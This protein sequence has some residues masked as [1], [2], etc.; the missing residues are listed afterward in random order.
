MRPDE[1]ELRERI[2]D[3]LAP[4]PHPAD[5]ADL[6][7]MVQAIRA[8]GP[9]GTPS[10]DAL[11]LDALDALQVTAGGRE[12][13]PSLASIRSEVVGRQLFDDVVVRLAQ[14]IPDAA[15]R[16]S[17]WTGQAPPAVW[18]QLV[19]RQPADIVAELSHVLP[20]ATSAAMKSRLSARSGGIWGIVVS[21][22]SGHLIAIEAA[23]EPG[24]PVTLRGA[25]P[26]DTVFRDALA[27]AVEAVGAWLRAQGLPGIDAGLGVVFSCSQTPTGAALQDDSIALAAALALVE[28]LTGAT[29]KPGGLCATGALTADGRVHPVGGA[30][31]KQEAFSRQM[32]VGRI[33]T[34]A[35]AEFPPE[36]ATATIQDAVAEAF[37]DTPT[38]AAR[39]RATR[40]LDHVRCEREGLLDH[41]HGPGLVAMSGGPAPPS[42]RGALTLPADLLARAPDPSLGEQTLA[43]LIAPAWPGLNPE[44]GFAAAAGKLGRWLDGPGHTPTVVLTTSN[45]A[46][47]AWADTLRPSAASMQV[48]LWR[49][50]TLPAAAPDPAVRRLVRR[51]GHHLDLRL[52]PTGP[53]AAGLGL[54][55]PNHPGRWLLLACLL[56]VGG[57]ATQATRST[58]PT[59]A[60]E[61][62]NAVVAD[63]ASSQTDPPTADWCQDALTELEALLRIPA[64]S[65]ADTAAFRWLADTCSQ[66]DEGLS[67]QARIE[68]LARATLPETARQ[69]RIEL[70]RSLAE[71]MV[72]DGYRAILDDL[73]DTPELATQTVLEQASRRQFGPLAHTRAA[74][75]AALAPLARALQGQQSTGLFPV[76]VAV[77]DGGIVL[78]FEDHWEL[79]GP[80]ASL[81]RI[82]TGRWPNDGRVHDLRF[83][84]Q[85]ARV[86]ASWPHNRGDGRTHLLLDPTTGEAEWIARLPGSI[87]GIAHWDSRL[88]GRRTTWLAGG[89]SIRAVVDPDGTSLPNTRQNALVYSLAEVDRGASQPPGLLIGTGEFTG[90]DLALWTPD[91]EGPRRLG[92]VRANG[93]PSLIAPTREPDTFLVAIGIKQPNTEWL[94]APSHRGIARI[95]RLRVL[96]DGRLQLDDRPGLAVP[97]ALLPSEAKA[98]VFSLLHLGPI[99]LEDDT[100]ELV[101]TLSVPDGAWTLL[102]RR[103]DAG[104]WTPLWMP[105]TRVVG[106][107]DLDGDDKAEVL[108]HRDEGAE[109][110]ILGLGRQPPPER[111][112]AL[113][114]GRPPHPDDAVAWKTARL[115]ER[116]AT[117]LAAASTWN[118]LASRARRTETATAARRHQLRTL[119]EAGAL[120]ELADAI[121]RMPDPAAASPTERHAFAALHRFSDALPLAPDD[122]TLRRLATEEARAASPLD[123][124]PHLQAAPAP[125][126]WDRGDGAL[127]FAGN[128]RLRTVAAIGLSPDGPLQTLAFTLDIQRLEWA[129]GV[130]VELVDEAGRALLGVHASADGMAGRIE[131]RLA[132]IA[133]GHPTQSRTH[134]VARATVREQAEVRLGIVPETGSVVCELRP[135]QGDAITLT[136]SGIEAPVRGLR[137]QTR[138]IQDYD[139]TAI[140]NLDHLRS[141]GLRPGPPPVDLLADGRPMDPLAWLRLQ[142]PD[143]L[144]QARTGTHTALA[145]LLVA[146]AE[147]LSDQ[148]TAEYLEAA[149]A[150]EKALLLYAPGD[151]LQVARASALLAEVVVRHER[152]T[153]WRNLRRAQHAI[154]AARAKGPPDDQTR[155]LLALLAA[156]VAARTGDPVALSTELSR[157][158]TTGTDPDRVSDRAAALAPNLG[159]ACRPLP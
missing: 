10:E 59:L 96:P 31:A 137:L 63:L 113:D 20:P 146:H 88:D 104:R 111:T 25:A 34:P 71:Q 149:T 72:W 49:S 127:R 84:P 7:A 5:R 82:A 60:S 1:V 129:S 115:V 97:E 75:L 44:L 32:L 41:L 131:R 74:P 134:A 78:G 136:A 99:D 4:A 2:A 68:A 105:D 85:G 67:R 151:T 90:Y 66:A 12:Q 117:P 21:G 86:V 95:G 36:M 103:D 64:E 98:A 48:V 143:G 154:Q 109:L 110:V 157:A 42:G 62:V 13:S 80:S 51:S 55:V 126:A 155:T 116:L 52:S 158:C 73:G 124:W 114:V 145:D 38:Q 24:P 132:C 89:K 152:I 79:R 33:L 29:V 112:P 23:I 150:I 119:R 6:E 120:N 93:I 76:Q 56:F 125:S 9:G 57:L 43:A 22:G 83:I 81:P 122:P 37:L 140:I 147:A 30:E 3:V 123:P 87:D 135:Q 28:A 100:D 53:T 14:G 101:A 153:G 26:A 54:R 15:D 148:N 118:R 107:V 141:R 8:T 16:W 130:Q 17:R 50:D 46:L 19:G 58:T 102:A 91:P 92:R 156:E 47:R 139:R 18:P 45:D 138:W 106:L 61:R 65:G 77:V 70:A 144:Q 27:L 121:L 94:P 40:A 11:F 128:D 108:L 133:H 35:Q 142:S 69:V 39:S 159:F